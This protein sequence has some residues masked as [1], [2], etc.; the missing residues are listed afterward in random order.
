MCLAELLERPAGDLGDLPTAHEED[1][2]HDHAVLI[3]YG[4]VG[5]PVAAELERQGIPYVVVDENRETV[6]ALQKRG[7]S[8]KRLV[9]QGYGE[10]CPLDSASTPA[11]GI[12]AVAPT[13]Q[14]SIS[15]VPSV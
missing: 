6:E 8:S 3:G 1:G 10:Y 9:S 4:R 2:L 13:D 5:A 12:S 7:V 11:A 15:P 14:G